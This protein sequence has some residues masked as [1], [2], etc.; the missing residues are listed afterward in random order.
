MLSV[1]IYSNEAFISQISAYN[2]CMS[3]GYHVLSIERAPFNM[4]N[5]LLYD[6][7]EERL[8]NDINFDCASFTDDELKFL[9]SPGI[10]ITIWDY[11]VLVGSVFLGIQRRYSFFKCGFHEYLAVKPNNKNTG[12]GT[13]LQNVVVNVAKALDLD[14]ILSST[15]IPADSS[16]RWHKKNGF[17]PYKTSSY[18][19]RNYQSYNFIKPVGKGALVGFLTIIAPL[20]LFV[21]KITKR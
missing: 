11:E 18:E 17:I 8:A 19:G 13:K 2:D 10:I 9:T 14:I 6:S 5:Q 20:T 3:L 15:A 1:C 7:F 4:V 21:S 12:I 16:V